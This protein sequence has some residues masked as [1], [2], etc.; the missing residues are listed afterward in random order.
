MPNDEKYG[1]S[2]D[3]ETGITVSSSSS[4]ALN[5]QPL[6]KYIHAKRKY[7]VLIAERMKKEH[8]ANVRAGIASGNSRD[9]KQ[10]SHDANM[11]NTILA[12]LQNNATEAFAEHVEL[13]G[14]KHIS[15]GGGLEQRK[16]AEHDTRDQ[17]GSA[18]FTATATIDWGS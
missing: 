9:S 15:S 11:S 6:I 3:P 17:I 7:A 10:W 18:E 14:T 13:Y 1:G 4:Y 5:S 2:T 8:D 16:A 12:R